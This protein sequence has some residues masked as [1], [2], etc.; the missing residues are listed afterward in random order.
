MCEYEIHFLKFK[1]M[2]IVTRLFR[3]L[4]DLWC[5]TKQSQEIFDPSLRSMKT[6][7]SYVVQDNYSMSCEIFNAG[8]IGRNLELNMH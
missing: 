7:E 8:G 4:T 1:P 6:I 3:F 5:I 2:Q